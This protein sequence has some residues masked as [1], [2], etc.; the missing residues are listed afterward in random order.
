MLKSS[1]YETN[2]MNFGDGWKED[3]SNYV[4]L[5][6]GFWRALWDE[7]SWQ[8][9]RILR[10]IANSIM[11]NVPGLGLSK[12]ILTLALNPDAAPLDTEDAERPT[13]RAS[14]S[15]APWRSKK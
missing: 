12:A 14:S 4:G 10:I 9:T 5:L 3:F 1:V 15:T 6:G 8:K 13:E 2:T 7:Q 11:G